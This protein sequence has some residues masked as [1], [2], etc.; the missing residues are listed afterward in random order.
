MRTTLAIQDSI[1]EAARKKALEQHV[2]LARF[3][4]EAV[5]ARL[6]DE[7]RETADPYRP[8]PTFTGQGIRPGVDLN[9]SSALLDIMGQH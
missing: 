7:V 2:S 1:L 8:L 6:A 5:R 3:I 9:D 4:E